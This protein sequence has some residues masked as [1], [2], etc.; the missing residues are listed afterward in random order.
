MSWLA[1]VSHIAGRAE[2]LLNQIDQNAAVILFK[3]LRST[4][5]DANR[6]DSVMSLIDIEGEGTNKLEKLRPEMVETATK[7][8]IRGG[9]TSSVSSRI[10]N[11]KK[12]DELIAYLNNSNEPTSSRC[13]SVASCFSAP[14]PHITSENL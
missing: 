12:D 11:R 1:K 14:N 3:A 8:H 5:K 4:K 13:S 7:K 9:H 6:S 2:D 10:H